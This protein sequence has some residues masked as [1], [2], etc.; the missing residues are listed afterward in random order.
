LEETNW[1][2]SRT[3]SIFHCRQHNGL[4]IDFCKLLLT[5]IIKIV[6]LNC[7]R[8]IN[9]K[10]LHKSGANCQLPEALCL[11]VFLHS[12]ASSLPGS[13]QTLNASE[14][15][16]TWYCTFWMIVSRSRGSVLHICRHCRSTLVA[17]N[18]MSLH[19]WCVYLKRCLS[20]SLSWWQP[21][22]G[23]L[24]QNP[25]LCTFFPTGLVQFSD[26]FL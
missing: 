22:H 6:W 26:S 17:S 10:Q 24:V 1:N 7:H 19:F 16:P 15:S 4:S 20:S 3:L 13:N 21:G 23:L 12:M 14:L 5:V 25:H 11:G 9:W 2:P 8:T 18:W